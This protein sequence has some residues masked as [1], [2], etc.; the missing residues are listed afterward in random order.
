MEKDPAYLQ[1]TVRQAIASACAQGSQKPRGASVI[2][3]AVVGVRFGGLVLLVDSMGVWPWR[4]RRNNEPD[5][6]ELLPEDWTLVV[7]LPTSLRHSAA[8]VRM[9]YL[10]RVCRSLWSVK[11][12]GISELP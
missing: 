2:R 9:M 4:C 8:T 1:T 7:V 5:P 6:H 12:V 10:L 11:M 3:A